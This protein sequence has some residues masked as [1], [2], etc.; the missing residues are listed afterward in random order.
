MTWG[1]FAYIVH[2][3][4]YNKLLDKLNRAKEIADA[5]LIRHQQEYLCLKPA[6]KLVEHPAGFSTIKEKQVNYQHIT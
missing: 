2:K 3:R 4:A 1:A 6:K 5:V